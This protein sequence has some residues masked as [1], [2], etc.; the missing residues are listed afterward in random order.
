MFG[1]PDE[2]AD[3]ITTPTRQFS[4]LEITSGLADDS[5]E[6]D[7]R[8]AERRLRDLRGRVKAARAVVSATPGA[9]EVL[10]RDWMKAAHFYARF[11]ITEAQFSNGVPAA[12]GGIAT[13]IDQAGSSEVRTVEYQQRASAALLELTG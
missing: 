3:E 1:G 13:V 6:A 8:A 10:R 12:N 4:M 2:D 11:A 7:E 9:E 5:R